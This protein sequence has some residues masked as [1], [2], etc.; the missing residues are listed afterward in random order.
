M[1][2]IVKSVRSGEGFSVLSVA[3]TLFP[4]PKL[5]PSIPPFSCRCAGG[6]VVYPIGSPVLEALFQ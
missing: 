3:P 5:P 6:A 4:Q 2:V 1:R